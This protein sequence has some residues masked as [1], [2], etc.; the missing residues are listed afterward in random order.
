[1]GSDGAEVGGGE[2]AGGV[3]IDSK[4]VRTCACQSAQWLVNSH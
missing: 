1:M 2:V 3:L 4:I